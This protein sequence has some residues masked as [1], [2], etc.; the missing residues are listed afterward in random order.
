MPVAVVTGWPFAF[1]MPW[2]FGLVESESALSNSALF[3]L[4]VLVVVGF[5]L[6]VSIVLFNRP[7]RLVPPGLRQQPGLLQERRRAV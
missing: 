5:A 1:A 3:T 2:A 4:A 6:M 7:K